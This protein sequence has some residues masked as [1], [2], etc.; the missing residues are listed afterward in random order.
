MN[1][2]NFVNFVNFVKQDVNAAKTNLPQVLNDDRYFSAISNHDSYDI[3]DLHRIHGLH[4]S[5]SFASALDSAR[6]SAAIM[7]TPF[8][9]KRTAAASG[10]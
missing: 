2:V 3:H 10:R 6:S 8:C 9:A 5:L 7:S 1:I 4:G